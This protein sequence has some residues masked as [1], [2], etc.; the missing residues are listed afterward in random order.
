MTQGRGRVKARQPEA[1]GVGPQPR[2]TRPA[3]TSEAGEAGEA[4]GGSSPGAPHL[5]SDSQSPQL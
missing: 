4:G 1:G 5:M 3:R 2:S